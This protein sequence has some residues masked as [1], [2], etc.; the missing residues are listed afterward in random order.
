[1]LLQSDEVRAEELMREAQQ[2]AQNRWDTYRQMSD[3]F[4]PEKTAEKQKES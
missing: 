1:M 2:D 4:T 3:M